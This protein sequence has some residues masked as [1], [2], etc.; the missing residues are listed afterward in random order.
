V[1]HL[2]SSCS[3]TFSPGFGIFTHHTHPSLINRAPYHVTG[4]VRNEIEHF[5]TLKACPMPDATA[6]NANAF[7]DTRKLMHAS[8]GERTRV[9][10]LPKN[11]RSHPIPIIS[12]LHVRG[13]LGIAP[14][15]DK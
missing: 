4:I 11:W 5:Y 6:I 14:N 8:K 10:Q 9:Y 2:S 7:Q 12:Q 15:V 1:E 3:T 13:P